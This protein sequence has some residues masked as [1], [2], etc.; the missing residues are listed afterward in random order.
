MKKYYVTLVCL[1]IFSGALKAQLPECVKD[2][3]PAGG[4][5]YPEDLCVFNDFLFFTATDGTKRNLYKTDGT[6]AGTVKVKDSL[7]GNTIVALDNKLIIFAFQ[8]QCGIWVSDGTTAGTNMI[9]SNIR[10]ADD[11]N[12]AWKVWNNKLYFYGMTCNGYN[13]EVWVTNGTNA[14]YARVR[15]AC[16]KNKYLYKCCQ[17]TLALLPM[18]EKYKTT[19]TDKT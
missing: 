6:E 5:G 14:Q 4:D 17:K 7:Y 12:Q 2:I 19:E 9:Y 10:I 16:N 11:F 8:P 3:N 1:I 13:C 15:N 18:P